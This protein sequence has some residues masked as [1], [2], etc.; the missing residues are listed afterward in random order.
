MPGF[1]SRDLHLMIP[2]SL[3]QLSLAFIMVHANV[4]H[5]LNHPVNLLLV[6]SL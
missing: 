6:D 1:I 5:A 4:D 3:C 2:N